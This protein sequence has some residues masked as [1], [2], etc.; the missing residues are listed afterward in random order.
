MPEGSK[1]GK[2]VNSLISPG[3]VI[4]GRV[5]NSVLS[6]GVHV[7]EQAIIR[8]SVVMANTFVGYHS[9]VDSCILDE[10]VQIGK[11]CYI[12]FGSSLLPGDCDITYLGKDVVVPPNTAIGRKCK[13][14]PKAGLD[15]FATSL[16]DLKTIIRASAK[17]EALM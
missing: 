5:E 16:V 17:K 12:G 13:V 9:V 6:P 10:G 11:F 4:K 14:L 7:E 15:D 2:V 3:C 1:D 8:N